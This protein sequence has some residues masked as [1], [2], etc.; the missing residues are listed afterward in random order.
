[1][2]ASIIRFPA[3]CLSDFCEIRGLGFRRF[4]AEAAGAALAERLFEFGKDRLEFGQE[5]PWRV[6]DQEARRGE[7]GACGLRSDAE[8][9]AQ[10]FSGRLYFADRLGDLPCQ[11][12]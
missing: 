7:A 2:T 8:F 10:A 12:V 3:H 11:F 4:E 1:M 5:R 6:D 9:D